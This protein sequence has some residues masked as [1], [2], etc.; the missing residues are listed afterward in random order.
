MTAH[1][2]EHRNPDTQ[3][4][5]SHERQALRADPEQTRRELVNDSEGSFPSL[6]QRTIRTSNDTRGPCTQTGA[7][8]DRV[9]DRKEEKTLSRLEAVQLQTPLKPKARTLTL[10]ELQTAM[11]VPFTILDGRLILK[12]SI[13]GYKFKQPVSVSLDHVLAVG[14][15]QLLRYVIES[16]TQNRPSLTPFV[17]ENRT[18][19]VL[20]RYLLYGASCSGST[21]SLYNYAEGVSLYSRFLEASPDRIIDDLKSNTNLVDKVKLENQIG[22]LQQ[23]TESLQGMGLSPSRVHGLVKEM[24]TFYRKNGCK[25]I[26]LP[27]KLSRKAKYKDTAPLPEQLAK[28]LEIAD[29]REKVIITLAA[30][31]GFREETLTKL[32][33]RHVRDDLETGKTPLHVHVEAE[34]V[35]GKYA[36]HDTF[37]SEETVNYLRLYIEQRRK[38]SPD[39]RNPPEILSDNSPLI[40]SNTSRTPQPVSSKQIRNTVHGLYQRASL[41]KKVGGRMYNFRVHS[42]RKFFKT[43][44]IV[45]GAPESHVEYWMGHVTDTYNQVQS[46]GIEK[47]RQEYASANVII[48]ATSVSP[49]EAIERL[50]KRVTEDPALL[51]EFMSRLTTVAIQH[52]SVSK[53]A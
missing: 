50:V 33:Y 21:K 30:L 14:D 17:I 52:T 6:S 13:R 19:I 43:Q 22:L 1:N 29:L 24:R 4:V 20:A 36:E 7:E 51:R 15:P 28:V 35:K 48:S 27:E 18:M 47:Q 9:Q 32:Q 23:W 34:I 45:A 26:E 25:E 37:L 5:S 53:P 8:R 3:R 2:N 12:T 10:E 11:P 44:F 39:G 40:R 49:D 42:L 46:L 38:G 41:L 31:G 16:C